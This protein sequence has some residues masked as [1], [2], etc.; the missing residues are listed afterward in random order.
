MSEE[1]GGT[2]EPMN[3]PVAVRRRAS[4][5]IRDVARAA[6]VSVGTVSKALNSGG[7]LRRETRERVI[8]AA[9]ALGFRPNDL[10]QSLHRGQSLTVG[11]ISTDAFCRFTI[12][13]MEG[14]E[15]CLSD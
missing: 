15:E 2:P 1:V 3:E 4:V 5:T 12:P 11:L 6:S 13:I 8:A 10:A 9:G 7:R 14:I